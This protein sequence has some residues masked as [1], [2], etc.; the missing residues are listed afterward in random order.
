[1]TDH[2]YSQLKPDLILDAVEAYGYQCDGRI[3]ALNSYENRVYQ[4]GIEGQPPLIAKFYRPDRW[5]KAQIDEEHIF[6]RELYEA[7][8]PVVPPLKQTNGHTLLQYDKFYFALFEKMGGHAPELDNLND[9]EVL[10]RSLGRLH[11]LGAQ[12]CFSERPEIDVV[13]FGI[14]SQQFLLENNF[15]PSSLKLSYETLSRDLIDIMLTRFNELPYRSIRLHGDCHIGNIL[16]RDDSALFVDFD[17]CRSGPAVQDLWMLLSGEQHEQQI[18]LDSILEGYEMFHDFD[19]RELSLI[20]SLRTLRL[21]NYA[22]WLARRWT[23]PAFTL[24]FPWFNTECYWDEH[25]LSLRE[26]FALLQ[27]PPLQRISFN[28]A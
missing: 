12:H 2:P 25:I 4:I 22:A 20:E 15:I 18:Q 11:A 10:G 23:D 21:M 28:N 17:D 14:K 8:W 9:L 5:S 27:E 19:N 26:Q 6:C 1:M 13:S 7:E 3:F 16:W 24:A